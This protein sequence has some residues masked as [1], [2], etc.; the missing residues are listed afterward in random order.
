[1]V[2]IDTTRPD[3]ALVGALA[4]LQL[5][6]RRVGCS[7]RLQPCDELRELLGLVGLSEVLLLEPQGE[8]E[9]G[10]ELGVE[11]VMQPGDPPV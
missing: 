11:E 8:A 6:A 1:M 10:E 4:R 3:L 2:V 9:G 5:T 7:I